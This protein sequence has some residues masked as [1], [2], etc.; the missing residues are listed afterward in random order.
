MFKLMKY[1]FRKKR[2][3]LLIIGGGFLLLQLWYLVTFFQKD[4]EK[5]MVSSI[6]LILF[7]VVCFFT[8]FILAISNYYKE[9]NSK[10]SY[11]IFMTP[12]NS[13]SIIFSKMLSILCMGILIAV[14]IV[15]LALLDIR[16]YYQA[17]PTAESFSDML[18]ETLRS[19]GV[20]V[21]ELFITAV[22]GI[23]TFLI[24]FFAMVSVG[25]LA[26]TLS[27]TFLQNSKLRGVLSA[28][29][30]LL[31]NYAITKIT[32]LLPLTNENPASLGEALL[33]LWPA[34]LFQLA[35]L[36]LCIFVS[37]KLLEKKVSL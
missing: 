26:V 4:P 37:G 17:V 5:M 21:N 2:N 6:F 36:I 27:L 35:V 14:L 9:L 19:L 32:A 18:K 8:V 11:L 20:P 15:L 10:S 22:S 34:T 33:S 16:L 24:E 29:L 12:N 30:F 7:S 23:F 25:Y 3:I 1:E 28:A 13:Y 31:I